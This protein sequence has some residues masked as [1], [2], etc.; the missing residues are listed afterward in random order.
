M[1]HTHTHC[2]LEPIK[3]ERERKSGSLDLS[4]NKKNKT[5]TRIGKVRISNGSGALFMIFALIFIPGFL[6]SSELLCKIKA[7]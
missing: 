4:F 6:F 2:A 1:R 5:P 3:R 7:V